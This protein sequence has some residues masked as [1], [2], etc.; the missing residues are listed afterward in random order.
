MVVP[1]QTKGSE[2]KVAET[3]VS[4]V[5]E[6]KLKETLDSLDKVFSQHVY[7]WLHLKCHA[8]DL[9]SY[10]YGLFSIQLSETV[11]A[12]ALY[13]VDLEVFKEDPMGCCKVTP[14][15]WNH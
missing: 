14:F 2:D 6:E 9:E 4:L 10:F 8:L 12:S 13:A 15:S 3:R 7:R 5:K 1:T 11:S